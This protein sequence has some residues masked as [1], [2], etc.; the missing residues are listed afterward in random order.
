[1]RRSR[2][3][4]R[5]SAVL[6]VLL[7]LVSAQAAPAPAV[8]KGIDLYGSSA[9]TIEELR[10]RFGAQI[11]KL[12]QAYEAGDAEAFVKANE[13][14]TSG[15][16]QV[17][18]FA[19]VQVSLIKYYD[20]GQPIYVTV[21]VVEEGDRTRR[22]S[23]LP[24]PREEFGDPDG[25][26]A[27]WKEYER[28]GFALMQKGEKVD[29][30]NC[31]AFHCVFGFSHPDLA[32]FLPVFD[33]GARKHRDL[34]LRIIREDRDDQ[35]RG[36]AAYLLAHTKDAKTLT[37]AMVALM[38]D[39][40]G[41]ARN[42]AMRVLAYMAQHRRDVDIPVGPVLKAIDYPD[43]AERNKA[44]YVLDGLADRPRHH[45]VIIREAGPTLLRLLRLLQPNNHDAAYSIL[46]KV[47][48]RQFSDRDYDAWTAWLRSAMPPEGK[49]RAAAGLAGGR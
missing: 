5:V 44:L 27:S 16:R 15:V 18:R 14:V 24:P 3:V 32:R 21:D 7:P 19:H 40:S 31:P 49:R 29:P 37:R 41:Y 4:C 34:L 1:M 2:V 30:Q 43:T 28:A 11:E 9:I 38:L 13:E 33:A 47:S 12:A 26:F 35:H 20:P 42:S 39:P 46:K 8:L 25:L 23:F 36:V 22:M 6:A 45:R 48:G 10:M 17:G